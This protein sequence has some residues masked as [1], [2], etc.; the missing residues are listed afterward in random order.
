MTRFPTALRWGIVLLL[1]FLFLSAV[2]ISGATTE[3]TTVPT[4]TVTLTDRSVGISQYWLVVDNATYSEGPYYVVLYNK[5]AASGDGLGP[6]IG[7]SSKLQRGQ[8]TNVTVTI[9]IGEE[10]QND[11]T[12]VA[13]LHHADNDSQFE[14]RDNRSQDKPIVTGGVPVADTANVT[15]DGAIIDSNRLVAKYDL[16]DDDDI[17]ELVEIQTAIDDWAN[18]ELPNADGDGTTID[19]IQAL[20]SRWAS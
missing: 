2:S 18:D 14:Y 5:S 10:L 4:A 11:A 15:A 3:S 9:Y 8:Q 1:T 17:S 7:N 13:V 12:L 20:I 19:E 6:V 16:D